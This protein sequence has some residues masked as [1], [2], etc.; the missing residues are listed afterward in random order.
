MEYNEIGATLTD[1]GWVTMLSVNFEVT[2]AIRIQKIK[3]WITGSDGST[4][5]FS[6]GPVVFSDESHTSY[7]R[8]FPVEQVIDAPA[9]WQGV[10][11]LKWDLQSGTY[12]FFMSAP[13][14]PLG[15][16][17]YG[18]TP[19]LDSLLN[20]FDYKD[21]SQPDNIPWAPFGFEVYGTPLSS[22]PEPSFY[23]LM[24]ATGL[25]ALAASRRFQPKGRRGLEDRKQQVP[26]LS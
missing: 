24:G 20:S 2:E 22:V 13:D 10:D 26:S 16:G 11:S 4:A 18:P 1:A 19:N 9:K 5:T 3:A 17:Y 25:L 15:Y 21:Y 8:T 12:R 6:V 7:Y 14:V 23:G